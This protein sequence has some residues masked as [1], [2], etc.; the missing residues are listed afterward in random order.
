MNIVRLWRP[1]PKAWWRRRISLRQRSNTF[2]VRDLS[3]WATRIDATLAMIVVLLEKLMIQREGKEILATLG[4]K[5][6]SKGSSNGVRKT[7]TELG[8]KRNVIGGKGDGGGQRMGP[9][10]DSSRPRGGGG[11]G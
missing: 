3:K 6:I 8:G 2:T 5:E 11:D 9:E 4:G 1:P 10:T 7:G